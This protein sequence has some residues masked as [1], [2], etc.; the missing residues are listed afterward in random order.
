MHGDIAES[1]IKRQE[2]LASQRS[3]WNNLWQQVAD[4]VSP[5]K[6][7]N[8]LKTPG[9]RNEEVIFDST[10]V[11]D[12]EKF[13]SVMESMLT[14][15]AQKWHSLKPKNPDL[16]N[17]QAV[18][19]WCEYVTDMLF[20]LRYSARANFA[21]QF[22]EAFLSL[23]NFGTGAVYV[24]DEVGRG[25]RYK[26]IFLGELYLTE[27]SHGFI[28]TVYR[29]FMLSPQQAMIEYG[30]DKDK[31]P[32]KLVTDFEQGKYDTQYCFIHAV[33]PQDDAQEKL[34]PGMRWASYHVCVDNKA[35]VRKPSGYFSFPYAIG[36]Y[37]TEP[38]EIYGRG[39]GIT[40]LADIKTINQM[41]KANMRAAELSVT[42]PLVAPTL[43]NLVGGVK[44]L[45][46]AVNYGAMS[47]DGKPLL[48]PVN[49]A[50]SVP[51]GLEV[52]E[53][54]RQVI[55]NAYLVTLFDILIREPGMTA[56]EALLRAQE[57]GMLLA[58]ILG[59]MQ[60][61]MIS[62]TVERE[63]DIISRAGLLPPPPEDLM[64]AGGVVL[65]IEY[66]AAINRAQRS[67]EATAIM[68]TLEMALPL[69]QVDPAVTK[70]FKVV[71]VGRELALIN[72]MPAKL[73]RTSEEVYEMQ[74]AE[75]QAQMMQQMAAA[76]PAMTQSV[77]DV[78][79]AG[80]IEAETANI[81][82]QGAVQ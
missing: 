65:N 64:E 12:S 48:A 68:Q 45:P 80:K 39:P 62:P 21:G 63:L 60:A 66:D 35:L 47:M 14:P 9:Q 20:S 33:I 36:R 42:P 27:N 19:E 5:G 46:G 59:R 69:A 56:T 17:N 49:L 1:I 4:K 67:E 18:M 6:G 73:L 78:A 57:R 74:Q 76:A 37:I 43:D 15:R 61:E 58:P 51:I 24:D 79:E 40:V 8:T 31:L 2:S 16:E 50:G 71:E 52:E 26:S 75:Q 70:L 53:Q 3:N 28:D 77:K 38:G 23:G 34:P 11:S 55:H 7:F 54:R 25:I 81:Q 41:S 82:Q 72:G 13:A 30:A 22:H 29:R 44:F 32:D 10:A